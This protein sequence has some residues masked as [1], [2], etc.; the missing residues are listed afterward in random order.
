MYIFHNSI[1]SSSY[2]RAKKFI[3]K[4]TVL[5]FSLANKKTKKHL[6]PNLHRI[7]KKTKRKE[8]TTL[9]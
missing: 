7:L 9:S 6:I 5:V 3:E 2:P 4:K 8:K 1:L